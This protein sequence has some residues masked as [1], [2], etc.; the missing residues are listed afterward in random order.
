MT[1]PDLSFKR[2]TLGAVVNRLW[3]GLQKQKLGDLQSRGFC[4]HP[5]EMIVT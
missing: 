3:E 5:R 2:L 1:Q 4:S